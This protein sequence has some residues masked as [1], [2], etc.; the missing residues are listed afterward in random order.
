MCSVQ[1]NQRAQTF[2]LFYFQL[3]H[4]EMYLHNVFSGL[5]VQMVILVIILFF[6]CISLQLVLNGIAAGCGDTDAELFTTSC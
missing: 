4:A 2:V 6:L 5:F 1:S 3:V